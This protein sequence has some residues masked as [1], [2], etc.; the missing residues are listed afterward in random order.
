VAQRG[1]LPMEIITRGDLEPSEATDLFCRVRALGN[2]PFAATI[3]WFAEPGR[4]VK[5]GDVVV[6]LDDAPF[7]EDLALRRVPLEQAHADWLM[8]SENH[9]IVASQ[10]E[11]DIAT[12]VA[13]ARLAEIDLRKY[14]EADHALAR[15]DLVGRLKMAESDLLA[16]REHLAFTERM[17][18]RGFASDS[19]AR[20]DYNRTQATQF[21]VDLLHAGVEVLDNYT[22]PL[23][24]ADLKG[25]ADEARRGVA[26][27]KEHARAKDIQ[28]GIDR[29]SKQRIYQKR[30]NRYHEI[31][32]EAAK[33]RIIAPH[34]GMVIYCISDQARSGIGGFQ[35]V[36]AEGEQVRQG[37]LLVR[38]AQLRQMVIRAWVHE[39]LIG[40]VH[41]EDEVASRSS[42]Q[43][44]TIQLD[45]L[46]NR[47]LHGH[48]KLV[49]TVPINSG[50]DGS[51]GFRATLVIDEPVDGLRPDMSAR[52]TIQMQEAPHDVLTVPVDAILPGL[53]NHRKLYVLKE[54]GPKEREVVV[55]FSNDDTAQIL[56]G[57]EEGE[58]V[59][60]NPEELTEERTRMGGGVGKHRRAR[61]K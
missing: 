22:H 21:G 55:G 54:E 49:G 4:W 60:V 61:N 19:Q 53:G 17:R 40:H 1:D 51:K 30:L 42:F 59:V 3:K 56:S 12:A 2:S 11:S 29:L 5:R 24:L 14:V 32:A 31:E 7:Q 57:L 37:Q 41:G 33:C 43:V 28:T 39:A 58:E 36:I 10:N 48:V 25:K 20:A 8:S 34:D 44:A 16:V 38:V 35:A 18:R 9:K 46:P 47:I 15:H 26:L 27:A 23:T 6:L 52:V 50:F 13:A 45:A